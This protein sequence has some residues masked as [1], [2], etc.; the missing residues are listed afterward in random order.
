MNNAEVLVKFKGDT[1]DLDQKTEKANSV[2]KG[3]GKGLAGVVG[4]AAG[5]AATAIAA[6]TKA[7]VDLTKASVDAY[8]DFEQ[9]A[10]GI[11]KL[12]G[13]SAD[14][15]ME[16]ANE[17]YKT[18][19]M[20]ANQYMS[21]TT[22]FSAKLL[23]DLG[24]DANAAA[25]YADK[26]MRQIADNA[27][28]YGKYT[29][30]ELTGVYQALAKGMYT[31]LDNLNLGFAG[32]K[33][34]MQELLDYAE[35]LS[36]RTFN[37]ENFTDIVD[38]IG[39]VQDELNITGTTAREAA[40]TITGSFNSMKAAWGNF[41]TELGKPDAD[42]EGVVNK[43]VDSV[44]TFVDN[45]GPVVVRIIEAIANALPMIAQKIGD[46]LPQLVTDLLPPLIDAVITLVKSLAQNLPTIIMALAQG[47]VQAI[48]GLAAILPQIL[49]ALLKATI[50]III[51]LAQ[52][53]PDLIPAII[54]AILGMIPVL[55]ENLPLFIQA[56]IELLIGLV[57][58]IIKAIPEL[59][60]HT[61]DIVKSIINAF[62][63]LP[64]ALWNAG[65]DMIKGLWN[66]IKDVTG[67]ITE[68]IKG[69]GKTVMKAIKGIFGIH[70]PSTE[71]EWV[72]KM[73]ILGLEK[74]M[75]DMQPQLQRTINGM[76][77]LQPNVSGTMNNSLSPNLNVVVQ[78]N[79]EMDPLGQ[80]V[81]RIKTFSGG[82]KND[83]NWGATQ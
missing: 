47:L 14:K 31:T 73:N 48:K 60:K 62:K 82:A 50:A 68:K 24:G 9:L 75:E 59:L 77:D 27:N 17:A 7:V 35:Q 29:I 44:M 79:M 46:L 26:A 70:S 13:D 55:I 63:D 3:F 65:K 72:G 20:T 69:F 71:F 34:G 66:G 81:N 23:R 53:L 8:A 2:L 10:G 51:A 52:A 64:M 5:I 78:N 30:D 22:A 56:G 4:V 40:Q 42:I 1:K 16:Y 67:W 41:I 15:V 37:I 12:Y 39:I 19:G 80:V 45:I 33:T 58:G 54:D 21:S 49:D 6:T 11:E 83:Y 57:T 43:L 36:G 74:G 32:S 61:K 38:A 18:V 28:T 76:F 25:E